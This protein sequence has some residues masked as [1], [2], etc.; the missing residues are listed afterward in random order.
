[1]GE[2]VKQVNEQA[3]EALRKVFSREPMPGENPLLELMGLLLGDGFG[4]VQSPPTLP[5]TSQQ[6]LDW[7]YLALMQPEGLTAVT[8]RVL[9]ME[10]RILPPELTAMRTWAASVLLSTLDQLQLM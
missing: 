9:E 2:F 10:Q 7:H 3:V 8:N 1:M 6:W 5:I 4:E